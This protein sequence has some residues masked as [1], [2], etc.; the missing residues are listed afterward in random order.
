[1]TRQPPL[2]EFVGLPASGKSHLARTVKHQLEPDIEVPITT[3]SEK[4]SRRRLPVLAVLLIGWVLL[5]PVRA[6][7]V[8]VDLRRTSQ[9][10]RLQLLRYWL[11]YLYLSAEWWRTA[12]TGEL[13]LSDQGCIQHVWRVRLTA[14]NMAV[15][16][17]ERFLRRHM[18]RMPDLVVF[19]EVDHHTRM[20]RGRERGTPVKAEHFDPEHPAIKR[21]QQAY[22]DITAAVHR[23]AAKEDGPQIVTIENTAAAL[24]QNSKTVADTIIR[25]YRQLDNSIDT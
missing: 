10:R 8:G 11:F 9:A 5:A 14:S 20:E 2:V 7:I 6:V 13:H 1:M 12:R 21:D 22:N 24:E 23:I 17:I 18:V 15:D 4:R 25:Q 3:A 19:V 16:D